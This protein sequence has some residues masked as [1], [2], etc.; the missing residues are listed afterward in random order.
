MT[1][2]TIY[3]GNLRTEITH[4]MSGVKLITDAPVDNHGEGKSFSPSDLLGHL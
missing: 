1:T 2:T 4:V 3:K